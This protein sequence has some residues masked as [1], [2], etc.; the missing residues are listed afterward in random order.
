MKKL[1]EVADAY[2]NNPNIT[3]DE[4][5]N[6][7]GVKQ[8]NP[9]KSI[10]KSVEFYQTYLPFITPQ[11]VFMIGYIF[12]P[13]QYNVKAEYKNEYTDLKK[14][15]L[16]FYFSQ[17]PKDFL[18]TSEQ[19]L[20]IKAKTDETHQKYCEK[21]DDL[22]YS[23]YRK[24]NNLNHA[25][26]GQ[27]FTFN[28]QRFIKDLYKGIGGTHLI[29]RYLVLN[30]L[31]D[32]SYENGEL[33]LGRGSVVACCIPVQDLP[34]N[35]PIDSEITVL[36]PRSKK[37]QTFTIN[38]QHS[39]CKVTYLVFDGKNEFYITNANEVYYAYDAL[40]DINRFIFAGYNWKR[41][42]LIYQKN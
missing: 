33:R 16:D 27:Y 26:E 31:Y 2:V 18:I 6:I 34:E 1:K 8:F 22:D 28:L 41:R 21:Y 25:I 36:N 13:E 40:F 3:L 32:H 12:N 39:E 24:Y 5:I 10:E 4:L 15:V 14:M 38:K 35:L 37:E 30:D 9:K 11:S 29:D 7:F 42:L 23:I 17:L 20:E 19:K